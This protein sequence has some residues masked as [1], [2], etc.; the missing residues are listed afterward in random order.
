[1]PALILMAMSKN[2]VIISAF[3]IFEINPPITGTTKKASLENLYLS[4]T[5]FIVVIETGTAPVEN[6]R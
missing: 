3:E 5:V 4:Q 2:F 1:M 6:P